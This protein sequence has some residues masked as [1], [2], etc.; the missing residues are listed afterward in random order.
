VRNQCGAVH[1]KRVVDAYCGHGLR[2]IDMAREGAQATGIDMDRGAIGAGGRLATE[3][4]A[5][6]RLLAAAVE[7]S[8]R[9]ELPADVAILNPPRRGVAKP[10][11]DALTKAPAGVV[12]YVSCNPATLARDLKRLAVSYDITEVRAFDL[13]PQT[14]HVETVVTLAR[15]R[16]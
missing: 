10:V 5:P 15:R 3:L 12:I 11:T 4:A 7:H 16:K 14:A 13:F 6:V 8:L 9:R 2:A 1:G